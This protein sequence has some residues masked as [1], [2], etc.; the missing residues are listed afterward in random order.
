MN[1]KLQKHEDGRWMTIGDGVP[2]LAT[3]P[4]VEWWAQVERVTALHPR[5]EW[6]EDFGNVLWWHLP[7]CE[8]P[9]VGWDDD[10]FDAKTKEGAWTTLHSALANG[11]VTHW[12]H[13]PIVWDGD[14]SALWL[15]TDREKRIDDLNS[16]LKASREIQRAEKHIL[17]A[18]VENN[19]ALRDRI[20]ELESQ[21]LSEIK[22]RVDSDSSQ[23]GKDDRHYMLRKITE[24]R[25]RIAELETLNA[26]LRLDVDRLAAESESRRR[27]LF[28]KADELSKEWRRAECAEAALSAVRKERG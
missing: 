3:A 15:S 18:E 20:A 24:L 7:I 2:R 26:R 8:E 23:F 19:A 22:G 21:R 13:L 4:E 12:S 28:E 17:I 11:W 9:M 6:H 25:D 14:G 10:A 1:C 16:G 5:S 27:V